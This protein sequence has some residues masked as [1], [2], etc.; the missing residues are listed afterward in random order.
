MLLVKIHIHNKRLMLKFMIFSSYEGPYGA[1]KK[2]ASAILH[3]IQFST[4]LQLN[5]FR[6]D[7]LLAQKTKNIVFLC[8]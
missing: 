1:N 6:S 2:C 4:T 3:R 7:E 8:S 5:V